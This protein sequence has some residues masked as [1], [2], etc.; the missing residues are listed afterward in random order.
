MWRYFLPYPP[1]GC[2]IIILSLASRE[3]IAGGEAV[4]SQRENQSQE[5]RQYIPSVRTKIAGVRRA[6]LCAA[7]SHR[8]SP[9]RL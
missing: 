4:Y 8:C 6:P 7:A 2:I 3:P 9:V 5:G 1:R